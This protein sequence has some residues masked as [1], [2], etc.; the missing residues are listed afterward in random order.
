[1]VQICKEAFNFRI[2]MTMYTST[3]H[4]CQNLICDSFKSWI[5]NSFV[6]EIWILIN[7]SIIRSSKSSRLIV[8]LLKYLQVNTSK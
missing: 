8:F 3:L 1:M 6:K 5:I 7:I 2:Q 4:F